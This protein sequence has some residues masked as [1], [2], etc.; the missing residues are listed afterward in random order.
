MQADLIDRLGDIETVP[1]NPQFS[2]RPPKGYA[3]SLVVDK[4]GSNAKTM[5]E[6]LSPARADG[7]KHRILLIVGK[8][9]PGGE[10]IASSDS[11][12]TG[13]LGAR[14]TRLENLQKGLAEPF[15]VHAGGF[16]KVRWTA[17]ERGSGREITGVLVYST[18]G[19]TD[20]IVDSEDHAPHK[21]D[22]LRI[23]EACASSFRA[24]PPD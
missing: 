9:R 24:K 23:V 8:E 17:Q 4:T 13:Y 5:T 10:S 18:L 12:L 21:N 15:Q 3:R 14:E 2:L 11:F 20:I 7:T 22:S 16:K 1:D 6:W 19:W